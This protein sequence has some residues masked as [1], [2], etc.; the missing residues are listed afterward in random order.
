[1][2]FQTAVLSILQSPLGLLLIGF[3]LTSLLGSLFATRLQNAA[4]E[5]QTRL[6]VFRK[7]YDEGIALLDHLS[8]LIDKSY[9]ALQRFLWALEDG[10]DDEYIKTKEQ[11]YFK[12]VV[13]WNGLLRS[14]RNKIRLLVGEAQ[15][16][17]FLDYG[18]DGRPENP[19]SIHYQHVK[20][21]NI[22]LAV[23]EGK[24]DKVTGQKEIERYNWEISAFL[25]DL[26]TVFAQRAISLSLLELPTETLG[27]AAKT[28]PPLPKS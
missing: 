3:L 9:F 26:T 6:E 5:R 15:A 2:N 23:K 14:N 22:V 17:R 25:E 28:K 24:L 13:E 7:R 8:A 10:N 27:E 12:M 19:K 18:D 4:W 1:M 11:E 21:H 16:N 20:V